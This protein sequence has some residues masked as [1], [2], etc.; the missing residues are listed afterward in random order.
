MYTHQEAVVHNL[1]LLK[2]ITIPVH[3]PASIQLTSLLTLME[4]NA[5][6]SP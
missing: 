1:L 5:Y 4:E 2:E 3:L 6:I